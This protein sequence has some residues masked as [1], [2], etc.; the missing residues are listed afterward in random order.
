MQDLKEIYYKYNFPGR[1]KLKQILK[2]ENIKVSTKQLNE[3]ISKQEVNQIFNEPVKRKGHTVSFAYLDR[4]QIDILNMD[5]Y[6]MK[7]KGFSYIMLV[8]D[9]FSRKLWAF[10][11]KKRDQ[12]NVEEAL[13][14]FIKKHKPN[15]IISD[16]EASFMSKQTQKLFNDN[17]IK[18][19]NTE[20]TDHRALGVIDRISRTI[21]TIIV[22]HMKFINSTA[23]TDYL[24]TI[25][26]MYNETPHPGILDL[27]PNEATKEENKQLLFD[28]NLEKAKNNN[29]QQKK[30]KVGDNIRI[31]NRK[32]TFERAYDKKYSDIQTIV[33]LTKTRA[34]LDDDTTVS[35]RRLKRVQ[36]VDDEPMEREM[37][38]NEEKKPD[39]ID[40]AKK[41][42]KIKKTISRAGLDSSNIVEGK[43]ERK[44]TAKYF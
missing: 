44:P 19:I 30:L 20:P 17:N 41:E 1:E 22:K 15:I 2:K 8:I 13:S 42:S 31:R 26:K 23:Y 24:P 18:H 27:T 32:K 36:P 43:R 10:L 12:S 14:E 9:I 35:L 6:S 38:R 39:V 5:E 40:E 28:Y 34:K 3:F 25:I 11:L 21:K 16:N 33:E 29:I 4:V 37:K 7:N